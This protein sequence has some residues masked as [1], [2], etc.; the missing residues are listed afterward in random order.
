MNCSETGQLSGT[1]SVASA[2]EKKTQQQ[3]H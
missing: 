1:C 2:V 3:Q